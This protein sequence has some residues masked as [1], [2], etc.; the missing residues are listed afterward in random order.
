MIQDIKEED[1]GHARSV[2]V[3]LKLALKDSRLPI[4]ALCQHFSLLSLTF[5][6]FFPAIVGTLG[7]GRITTLWLTVPPWVSTSTT[8]A[9]GASFANC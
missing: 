7:F 1:R 4:F 9:L 3:G 5:Q 8:K 2:R 6:Y